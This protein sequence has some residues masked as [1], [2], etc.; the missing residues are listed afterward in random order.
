MNTEIGSR[1]EA[2]Q[3]AFQELCHR[4]GQHFE[5]SE[6]RERVGRY[7]LGLLSNAERKNGWQIAENVYERGP[8]GMQR[9]LNAA[10]WDVEAVRDELRAYVIEQLGVPDGVLIVDETGFVKKGLTSVGVARQYSGTAGRIENQQ[11]GVFLAYASCHGA[12][13]IDRELY[14][15]EEWTHDQA[16]CQ[17]AGVPETVGFAAKPALAQRMLD[18][19]WASQVPARWVVADTVYS[20]DEL[21]LWLQQHGYWYVLA[22]PCS[23]TVWTG[24]QAM[25]VSTLAAQLPPEA[26]V[27]LSAGEG[28]QGPRYYDWGWCQLPYEAADGLAHWLIIR[29]SL[30]LPHELAYYHAYAPATSSLADLVQVAGTRWQI[31][32]GFEQAKGEVGL[33]H[34]EVRHWTAWYRH[35]T[36]TL[37]AHAFLAILRRTL[38]QSS[39]DAAPRT[40]P[41]VRRLLASLACSEQERQHRWHWSRWRQEHQA[42]A[43]QAHI[44]RRQANYPPQPVPLP[45]PIQLPGIPALSPTAWQAIAALL[46]SASGPGRPSTTHRQLLEAILWVMRNGLSWRAIPAAFGPWNSVYARYLRWLK[47]GLWSQIV[48]LL[49]VYSSA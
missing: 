42:R 5:R 1:V 46:L 22:V 2:W 14:L 10:V 33:D 23:Y 20:S 13:F 15:P 11:L 9:L 17:A 21:R 31:E 41:E 32:M 49:G 35:I 29:R 28:S 38:A 39:A 6:P 25:P 44:R 30:H 7:L 4:L 43:K 47:S 37:L 18:R 16:R 12:A 45:S 40:L 26:W 48:A 24:G 27:R 3:S 36:L 34:Y 8:Q 19:A